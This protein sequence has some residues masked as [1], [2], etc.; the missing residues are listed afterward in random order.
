MLSPFEETDIDE[1]EAYIESFI[2][3][4]GELTSRGELLYDNEVYIQD[5]DGNW[6]RIIENEKKCK[7]LS[8]SENFD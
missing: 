1:E 6:C 4:K 8:E 7:D 3:Y 2:V 5:E